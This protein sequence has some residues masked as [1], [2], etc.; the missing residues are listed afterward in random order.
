MINPSYYTKKNTVKRYGSGKVN[1]YPRRPLAVVVTT[2][3]YTV[4][5]GDT[6]YSL[7][8][9]LFGEERQYMWTIIGDLNPPMYPDELTA[10][11][12][13]KLPVVVVQDSITV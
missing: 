9:R 3:D 11:A 6:Y 8:S 2:R 4:Q 7:A 10:G 12:T 5:H 1:H 13:I